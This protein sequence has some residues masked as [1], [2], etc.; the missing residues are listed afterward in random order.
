MNQDTED[1]CSPSKYE[2]VIMDYTKSLFIAVAIYLLVQGLGLWISWTGPGEEK[3]IVKMVEEGEVLPPVVEEP[4]NPISSL[5]IFLYVIIMTGVI[6]ILLKYKFDIIIKIFVLLALLGGLSITFWGLIGWFGFFV[7]LLLFLFGI[8]KREN[9]LLM[10]IIL[11]FTIPGIGSWLGSSL[12]FIPSLLLLIG[13]AIYDIIAVFGTKHMVKLAE[14]AKGRIPMMFAIP[15]G[16]RYLG[17]GTGDLAIPLTFS[18]SI[19]RESILKDTSILPVITAS[20]GGCIGLVALFFY[21]L[22]K[23]DV[24]LPALPPIALGLILGFGIGMIFL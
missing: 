20:L 12:G 6:L 1:L 5:Q 18:V 11:I 21:V 4:E 24:T 2:R 3:G 13:L 14:E 9:I 22:N 17:L 16:D 15:I 7:A 23:K 10:N 8:W 19:L